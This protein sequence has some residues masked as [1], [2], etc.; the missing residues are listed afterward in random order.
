[1]NSDV[2]TQSESA[3]RPDNQHPNKLVKEHGQ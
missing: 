2:E 3:I 1:M